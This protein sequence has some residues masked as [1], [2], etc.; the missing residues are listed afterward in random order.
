[1]FDERFRQQ[2]DLVLTILGYMDWD[3]CFAMK[4]GTALNF[5]YE[6]M[7]RLSVDIDL[8]YVPLNS[9]EEAFEEMIKYFNRCVH[10]LNKRGFTA[11]V[12][13]IKQENP[14]GRLYVSSNSSSVKIEPNL[15]IRGA[16]LAPK[17]KSLSSAVKEAFSQDLKVRCLD[18]KE[19]MAGK[20]VA[21]LDR[22]HPRD[23]FD[24]LQY[25]KN[26]KSI[27][28]IMDYFMVYLLQSSRP[29]SE[30]IAPRLLNIKEIFQTNF[31]GMTKE[32][33]DLKE[34]ITYRNKV[35][36]DV[37]KCLVGQR[38]EFL[39]SV[40]EE[41]PKWKLIPFT[42]VEQF[43]GIKWKLQNIHT[44]PQAKREAEIK[45]LLKG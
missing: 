39:I 13:G 1:M 31:L 45:K 21:M 22:Q 8:V 10:D 4:G 44:M 29:F 14:I 2:V 38:R 27:K 3:G 15:I 42:N 36:K 20:L 12:T 40:M 33:M 17:L 32:P 25:Y 26:K 6:D 37:Q 23:I 35:I 28:E 16:L 19:I 24:M 7:P 41:R 9:R 11:K 43:P 18:Y 30:L 5:F 34:L